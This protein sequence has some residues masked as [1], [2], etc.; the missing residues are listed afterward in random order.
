MLFRT[1]V[2][3]SKKQALSITHKIS[4][5]KNMQEDDE[6]SCFPEKKNKCMRVKRAWSHV[7]CWSA[8]NHVQSKV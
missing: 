7:N 5:A 3:A 2:N 6:K 4:R 1:A 8:V